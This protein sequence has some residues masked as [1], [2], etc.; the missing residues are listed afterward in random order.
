MKMLT[1][2]ALSTLIF[3][4][5]GAALAARTITVVAGVD[6]QTARSMVVYA[7]G[8]SVNN[9]GHGSLGTR[10]KK[11]GPAGAK[12]SFGFKSGR[13]DISCGSSVLTKDSVVIMSYNG[14]TCTHKVYRK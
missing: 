5:T 9:K 11:T 1:K 2:V 3:A 8:F 4:V 7:V 10:T 12:Y 13:G 6:K 14:R